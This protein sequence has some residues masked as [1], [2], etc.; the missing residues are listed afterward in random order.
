[1]AAPAAVAITWDSEGPIDSGVPATSGE[2]VVYNNGL[3]EYAY[4]VGSA[5]AYT[6]NGVTFAGTAVGANANMGGGDITITFPR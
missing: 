1:M 2:N 5:N 6:F 3:I 4:N